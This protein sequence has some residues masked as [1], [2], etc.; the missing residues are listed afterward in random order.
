M[1]IQF[2]TDAT[3]DGIAYTLVPNCES[4]ATLTKWPNFRPTGFSGADIYAW[5]AAQN[6]WGWVVLNA[7]TQNVPEDTDGVRCPLSNMGVG[8]PQTMPSR[9][10]SCVTFSFSC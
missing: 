7:L 3:S 5:D 9:E 10:G 4:G 2:A 8:A 1:F 6:D